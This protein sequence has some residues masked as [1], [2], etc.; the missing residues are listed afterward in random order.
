MT[1]IY[2]LE[3]ELFPKRLLSDREKK[4]L[5]T[6]IENTEFCFHTESQDKLANKLLR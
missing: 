5:D 3:I 2:P 4:S 6:K 1:K